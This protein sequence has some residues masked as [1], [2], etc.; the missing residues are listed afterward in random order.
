MYCARV[1]IALVGMAAGFCIGY[2]L[3]HYYWGAP[4]EKRGG[5]DIP[6]GES[7]GKSQY[8]GGLRTDSRSHVDRGTGLPVEVSRI[9]LDV[10]GGRSKSPTDRNVAADELLRMR[11][12]RLPAE[13]IRMLRDETENLTWRNYCV[14]FL[15]SCYEQDPQPVV[16]EALEDTCQHR[17]PELSSCALWSLAQ[18][19]V[20]R[21][22]AATIGPDWNPRFEDVAQQIGRAHV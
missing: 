17:L 8:S 21:P 9:P 10:I 20:P 1:S 16:L 2:C 18:L 15:R 12:P 11:E 13:L 22:W 6:L 3:Y 14:Q 7:V 19:A 5:T 4:S